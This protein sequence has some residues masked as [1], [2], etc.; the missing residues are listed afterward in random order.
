MLG[1]REMSYDMHY[2][3]GKDLSKYNIDELITI[4]DDA[5]IMAKGARENT[6]INNILEFATKE[7]AT[8]YLKKYLNEDCTILVKGS[9]F[10]KLEYIANKLKEW[11]N[12]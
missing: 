9:R 8:V 2:N 10:L 5:K 11:G 12:E 4:G 6:N 7:E 3:V 1:Y